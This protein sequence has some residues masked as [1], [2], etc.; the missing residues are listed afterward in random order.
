MTGATHAWR[1]AGDIRRLARHGALRPFESN[2]DV[3]PPARLAARLLRLGSNAPETP[4]YAGGLKHCG[5][6][7]VK[8]GQALATRPDLVGEAAAADLR[9]LQDDLSPAPWPQIEAELNAAL[10]G[11]WRAHFRHIEQAPIGAASIAQVHKAETLDGRTVALKILRPG[12]EQQFQRALSSYAWAAAHL[13][14]L[15]GEF[16][17]LKPRV[18]IETFRQWTNAELDLRREAGNASELAEAVRGAPRIRVPAVVWEQ[19]TRRTLA[20]EWVEG[21]KLTDRAAVEAT[22]ADRHAL[23]AALV[24]GFL[25]QAIGEGFFHADLHQG[26]ILLTPEGDLVLIDFGIMGRLDRR[27]RVYLAEILYGLITGNYRRVAE[28]HFEAGYVP[29][30]HD[31]GAFATALRAVGE[32]IRGRSAGDISVANLLDGLFAITR[33]FDMAVQPHLLLLQKTM[34]MV[35]GVALGLDPRVNMWD[36]AA[37]YVKSWIRDELGPEAKAADSLVAN[38]RLLGR[39]PGLARRAVRQLPAE[40][41]APPL[42]PLPPLAETPPSRWPWLI[43]GAAAGAALTAL[44]T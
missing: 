5:P 26:N 28:I 17:R 4:D 21:V 43:A 13:E 12:V 23:A 14:R 20:L 30:H 7:A 11:G 29:P 42:P 38:L 19:T 36:V 34:V 10:S 37:P 9:K 40:S 39:L 8:L 44:F 18:V 22:G 33:Q 32:P 15:G 27:A 6:A 24:R 41:A 31:I 16:E 3:P 1:L 25:A 2:P 35:E